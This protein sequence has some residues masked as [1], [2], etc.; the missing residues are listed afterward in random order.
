[1]IVPYIRDILEEQHYQDVILVLRRVDRTPEGVTSPPDNTVNLILTDHL[2]VIE[3]RF[4]QNTHTSPH[5]IA[6]KR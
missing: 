4:L 6:R 3:E 2:V 1:M 5:S